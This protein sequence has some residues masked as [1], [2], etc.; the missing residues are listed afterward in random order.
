MTAELFETLNT[1]TAQTLENWRKLGETNLKIGERLLKEQVELTTALVEAA[2]GH[3]QEIAT[4]KDM[5]DVAALQTEFVQGYSKKLMD[6]SRSCADILAEAGKVYN[7]VF[8]AGVKAAGDNFAGTK[9]A[10]GK[11]AA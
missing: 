2:T 3:A 1:L 7:Q 5:K 9:A 6:S 11:K 4:T 10:K 8:E